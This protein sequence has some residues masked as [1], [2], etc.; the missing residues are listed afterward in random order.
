MDLE[1]EE[2][3]SVKTRKTFVRVLGALGFVLG[4]LVVVMAVGGGLAVHQM[5]QAGTC[6][7]E[8]PL[9]GGGLLDRLD[10]NFLA[11]VCTT[12]TTTGLPAVVV[13]ALSGAGLATGSAVATRGIVRKA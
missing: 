4:A 5:A 11:R 8:V 10:P 3:M 12:L 13:L 1:K 2:A 7:L 9:I 6:A